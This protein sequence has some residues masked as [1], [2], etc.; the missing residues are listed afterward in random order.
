MWICGP[1]NRWACVP[2]AR[3]L[4]PCI[5]VATALHILGILA[6]NPNKFAMRRAKILTIQRPMGNSHTLMEGTSCRNQE[7]TACSRRVN[8]VFMACSRR[9]HGVFTTC[10][11]R[12]HGVFTACSRK[13]NG[14]HGEGNSPPVLAV[15]S[16]TVQ[17]TV[18]ST[19]SIVYMVQLHIV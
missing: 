4:T 16:M 18:P 3:T 7:L 17:S 11:R 19:I 10:S 15:Y 9:V 13:K 2:G 12:V 6:H 5:H 8:G 14:V 1:R